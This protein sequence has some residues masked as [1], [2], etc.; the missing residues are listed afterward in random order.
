MK[1]SPSRR[2]L[3]TTAAVGSALA[4]SGCATVSASQ[5]VESLAPQG[6]RSRHCRYF[7]ADPSLPEG[8][9]QCSLAERG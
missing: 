3:L 4:V 7:V 5:R 2:E 1:K 9:G 8:A 6:C